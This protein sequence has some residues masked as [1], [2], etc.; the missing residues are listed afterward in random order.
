MII[1]CD[2]GFGLDLALR[3]THRGF[4]VFAGCLDLGSDG[5]RKLHDV[6]SVLQMDITN[7]EDVAAAVETVSETLQTPKETEL[8][9][10]VNNAGVTDLAEVEWS[11]LDSLRHMFDVNVLG[12]IRVTQAFL[13]LIR[14]S[15]GHLVFMGSVSGRFAYPGFVGYCMT[16]H[17]IYSL[18]SGLRR[19]MRK[20][21]V[22]VSLVEP[23]LY[24]TRM[25]APQY[26][27]QSL[28]RAWSRTA[29]EVR[30]EYGGLEY[31]AGL[32]E[33]WTVRVAGRART[34]VGEVVDCLEHAVE[35]THPRSVY[36]CASTLDK[37]RFWVMERMLPES[38]LDMMLCRMADSKPSSPTTEFP[39]Q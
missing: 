34:E 29:A 35:A 36:R 5:A 30:Q 18:A 33:A 15:R 14:K 38:L 32:E 8:W 17:S 16:K 27:R 12:T 9:A 19:E 26:L 24:R 39:G 6:A 20:W 28:R 25:T 2:S 10:L 11:D 31:L 21:G 22:R 23:G 7:A 1:G 4:R 3:L 37:V 13:P